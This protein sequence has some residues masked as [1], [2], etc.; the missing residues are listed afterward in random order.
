MISPE[1]QAKR[2][3]NVEQA[4]HSTRL[5]GL[6]PSQE[7]LDLGEQW[8]RDE[9]TLDEWFTQIKRKHGITSDTKDNN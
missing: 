6:E 9:I 3:Y 8:I 1:E 2:R 5:E 4:F 7:S